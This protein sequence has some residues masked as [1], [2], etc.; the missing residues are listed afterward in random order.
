[1]SNTVF[2]RNR[3]R[4]RAVETRQLRRI[5]R[6][7]LEELLRQPR[8]QIGVYLVGASEMAH[9]NGT[10]LHHEGSTDVIT[11]DYVDQGH[12]VSPS[13]NG[14]IFLCVDEAIRQARTFRATW[15]HELARYAIHGLLHLCGFDDQR[16]AARRRMKL[17]EN[18]LLAQ[19][20]SHFALAKLK[21]A[22]TRKPHD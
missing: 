13:L 8:F 14:E 16:M 22:A 2:V 19:V 6:F 3:Q 5:V 17:E 11:F 18:R 15:Q 20:A 21:P 4:T 7:V 12:T 9:L 10:F 1:M